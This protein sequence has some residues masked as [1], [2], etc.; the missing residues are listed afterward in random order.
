MLRL[1][2]LALIAIA[3]AM[4]V[5]RFAP[6]LRAR[7]GG[8]APSFCASDPVRPCVQADQAFD[9]PALVLHG[10]R[11]WRSAGDFPDASASAIVAPGPKG[12]YIRSH[13]RMTGVRKTPGSLMRGLNS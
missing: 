2:L 5:L 3:V 4:L 6:R 9:L 1:V 7:H 13:C 8:G 10:R 11:P 12:R